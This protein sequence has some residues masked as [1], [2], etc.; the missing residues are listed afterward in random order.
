MTDNIVVV[1]LPT[2]SETY[3]AFSKLKQAAGFKLNAAAVVE[4]EASG[5]VHLADS[6]Y[7]AGSATTGGSLIGMLVGVLGG[8]LGMLLGMGVGALAGSLVD[9]ERIDLGDDI[10]SDFAKRVT[11]GGNA[12]LAHV[13]EDA[14]A[15][16]DV[17]AAEAK[18][19]LVR[20][21]VEEVVAEVEAQ[22]AAAEAAA[23][24]A[25]ETVRQQKRQERHEKWQERI[26]ALKSRFSRN[27]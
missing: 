1:T 11:P 21:P 9:A 18:A 25:R 15:A 6:T 26:E 19:T 17:F 27:G 5:Q 10:V 3:E 8:P 2:R 23:R 14:P 12:I 22:Q 7:Q 13:S 24:A 20:Y 4:R 16:L